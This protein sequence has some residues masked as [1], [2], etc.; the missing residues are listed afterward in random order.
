[1]ENYLNIYIFIPLILG[2]FPSIFFRGEND[3]RQYRE[4]KKPELIPPSYVF[5][6]VWPILY[7]LIGISYYIA[8]KNKKNY[9]YYI[10]PVIGLIINYSYY[11]IFFGKNRLFLSL[12]IVILTLLFAILTLLQFNYT[13]K[14]K[15]SVYLLIPYIMWLS[16]ATYL[17]YNI[18]ILNK[19]IDNN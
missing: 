1:M 5:G 6:I 16:F 17:S 3:M 8:L 9:I 7:L 2:M 15:L 19:N 4:L 11:P 14:N 18:Y 12:I 10:I 13:E